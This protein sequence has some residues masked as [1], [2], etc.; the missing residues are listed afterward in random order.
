MILAY[1]IFMICF[2][3]NEWLQFVYLPDFGIRITV[4]KKA[5]DGSVRDAMKE[6]AF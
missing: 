3:L 5:K 6:L 2:C 1:N 4:M